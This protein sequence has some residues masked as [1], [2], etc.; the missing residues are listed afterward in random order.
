MHQLQTIR[1]R[2]PKYRWDLTLLLQEVSRGFLF[3]IHNHSPCLLRK[4]GIESH[5]DSHY[6]MVLL[7]VKL[8]ATVKCD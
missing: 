7:I 4:W 5:E 6:E 2:Q 8:H 3:F 1:Q